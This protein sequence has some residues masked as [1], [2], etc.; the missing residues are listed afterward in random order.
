MAEKPHALSPVDGP[1]LVTAIHAPSSP[2]CTQTG[3]EFLSEVDKALSNGKLV[4]VKGWKPQGLNNFAIDDMVM[5]GLAVDQK[6]VV[7]GRLLFNERRFEALT[8]FLY[9]MPSFVS[10]IP[11]NRISGWRCDNLLRRRT[12]LIPV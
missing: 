2:G 11:K 4:L 12:I 5:A 1:P 7:Q 3:V 8:F 10:K 9:Q 6:V